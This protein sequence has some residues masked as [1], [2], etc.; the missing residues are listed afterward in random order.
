M[1]I[2]VSSNSEKRI[3]NAREI[4]SIRE[5]NGVCT[6][7]FAHQVIG[8]SNEMSVDQ[9]YEDLLRIVGVKE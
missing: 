3:I 1:F 7:R 5:E 8:I 9:S 2:E 6:L 4:V